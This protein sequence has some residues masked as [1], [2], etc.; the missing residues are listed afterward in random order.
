MRKTKIV[1]TL[2][3]ASAEP[4]ILRRLLES[5]VDVVRLNFSH[6]DHE[7]HRQYVQRIRDAARE[8]DRP[9]AILQDLQGPKIRTGNLEQGGPVELE[10]DSQV[11]IT[12]RKVVGNAQRF[13]TS[14]A[15]LPHD[16]GRGDRILISDGS[17]EL[18]VTECRKDELDCRVIHGGTLKERQGMNLPGVPLS[19]PALTKKDLADVELGI[20]LDVDY[21]AL[22]FVRQAADIRRLREVIQEAGK[23]IPI[24]AKIEKPQAVERL[25]E[26]LNEADGLMVARGDLGVEM[27]TEKVPIIQKRIID[28]A[29]L[30]GKPVI[31]ATQMLES[32]IENPQP[33][34][35]EASD[36]ANAILD[37]T[38]AVMLSGETSIGH[39]PL[40]TVS[41]MHK[42]AL[43]TEDHM[44]NRPYRELVTRSDTRIRTALAEAACRLAET[45]EARAIVPF[46]LSGSTA[47]AISKRQPR[48]P[49]FALTPNEN[50][51]RRMALWRGVHGYRFATFDDTDAMIEQGEAV[52]LQRNLAMVGDLM[53]CIAGASTQTPGGNN[54]L[55]VHYFDGHNPYRTT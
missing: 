47:L 17:L 26:I 16:V 21:I 39:F 32:M 11:T 37:G 2:G 53:I 36:V 3:P 12:T 54:L 30:H 10:D 49:I 27:R 35:A 18:E 15:D 8:M 9:I 34:R 6:G 42:I 48:M 20:E 25:E 55:Q 4:T 46:T 33:T 1:A 14:Y 22:S 31:T 28:M 23:D 29:N 40:Q 51:Y 41:I 50:T 13:S 19:T 24:I 52:L 45:L 38:D 44:Q 43:E 7:T 5:G